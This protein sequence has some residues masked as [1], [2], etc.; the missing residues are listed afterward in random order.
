MRKKNN[1]PYPIMNLHAYLKER[2]GLIDRVL[3]CY[4]GEC[5]QHLE[6]LFKVERV[7]TFSLIHDDLPAPV[8]SP[9]GKESVPSSPRKPS[10][11]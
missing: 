8:S 11:L 10:S 4:L 7:Q 2:Q 6:M 5:R 3:N 1:P 9:E